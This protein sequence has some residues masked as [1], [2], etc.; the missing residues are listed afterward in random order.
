MHTEER[1][2][3]NFLARHFLLCSLVLLL[4]TRLVA[5]FNTA[6]I[7]RDSVIYIELA[8]Y[9]VAGHYFKALAHPYHPLYPFLIAV[10]EKVSGFSFEHSAVGLSIIASALT[11]PALAIIYHRIENRLVLILGMLFFCVSP[12]LI[13]YSADVLTEP[14]YLLFVAWA[15][16]FCVKAMVLRKRRALYY[17]FAGLFTGLA[18]L[19]R[20]EGLVVGIAGVLCLLIFYKSVRLEGILYGVLLMTVGVLLVG[21]PYILYL[22]RNTGQWLLTRKKRV[23]TLIYDVSGKKKFQKPSVPKKL[24]LPKGV[25]KKRAEFLLNRRKWQWEQADRIRQILGEPKEPKVPPGSPVWRWFLVFLGSLGSV[26][27][28]FFNGMFIPIGMWVIFRFF[29]FKRYPWNKVDTF[30]LV[31]SALYW[32]ML[33]VLLSGYGYVSRRHYSP[34]AMFWFVWAAVGFI[35]ACELI[36][37]IFNNRHVTPKIVGA[38]LIIPVLGISVIKGTKPY[39][40]GK[41]GRKVVG[42]WISERKSKNTGC[43]ILTSMSRVGYYA[44]CRTISLPVIGEKDVDALRRHEI[45]YVVLTR[46]EME[47]VPVLMSLLGKYGY[48]E[49]YHYTSSTRHEDIW[50]FAFEG[51]RAHG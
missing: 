31:F 12:Y 16:A 11:L 17:F 26:L 50:I 41:Y 36:A 43:T 38:I 5:W 27:V 28:G 22:H 42:M 44:G 15:A 49:V 6:I 10:A 19:T 24:M 2:A 25:D 35:Y 46:R 13:R 47:K 23:S 40:M 29:C 39:R 14:L 4:I 30:I 37:S 45:V 18:Y 48:R 1:A 51:Q 8:R 34:V 33:G 3:G 7:S 9:W 32:M 20:P 21:S